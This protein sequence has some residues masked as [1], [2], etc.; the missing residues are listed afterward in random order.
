MIE[1][2]STDGP[3]EVTIVMPCLNEIRTL[4]VCIEKARHCLAELDVRGEIV[5]ADNG[6]EDGSVELAEA[7]GARVV[8]E[9]KKGYGAALKAGI[10]AARGKYVI[11]GDCDDSYDFLALQPFVE[12]LREGYDLVVGNRFLGG[13]APGAMPLT[14]RYLG[15]PLLSALGRTLFKTKEIGDFYCGLRGFRRDLVQQLNL[16]SDGMEF[17]LE[18]IVK[19]SLHGC[20]LTEV[21]TTLSPDGR[22]REPH[23]RRFRDGWRSV[24]FYLLMAPRWMF[25]FPGIVLLG[26]G[27]V[28][29]LR[30]LI[31]PMTIGGITFD[32]HTLLYSSAAVILGYQSLLLS[33]FAK[34]MATQ[35]GLHPARTRLEPLK[36]RGTLMYFFTI[37]FVLSLVGVGLGALATSFW[38][39]TGFGNL[40]PDRV[41]RLVIMSVL[42]LVIGGQTMMAGFYF[43][44]YNLVDEH[45]DE[46]V[47]LRSRQAS[48]TG[49]LQADPADEPFAG[50]MR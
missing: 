23:L 6:S 37:G 50:S 3:V 33:S 8:Y 39:M 7:L 10:A 22:D 17:A 47:S 25:A 30:L 43:G 26:I 9:T 19:G 34:L 31:G 29:T 18:M 5:V 28:V 40:T 35:S 46:K 4:G 38:S 21:P 42:F 32:Y 36:G 20:K 45:R 15:N 49:S 16:H 41:T 44:L 48:G 2:Q 13:I 1:D 12:K 27:A 11:M 24:R 14:H